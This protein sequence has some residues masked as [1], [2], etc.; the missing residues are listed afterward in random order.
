MSETPNRIEVLAGELETLRSEIAELDALDAPTDEQSERF[1]VALTE[2]DE[3]TAEHT[4]LVERA[5]KVAKVRDTA[6]RTPPE[7]IQAPN[8]NIQ[9]DAFE[10]AEG[11]RMQHDS[12][13]NVRF[14]SEET[15]ER[16][17]R[18]FDGA[19]VR[20]VK[21]EHLE[22]LHDRIET[23][24]GAAEYAL[25]HGSPAYRSAFTE[26]MRAKGQNVMLT[27]HE[28]EAVRASMALGV[29]TGGYALPTLLDPTLIHT[30]VATRNPIR[31][32]RAGRD[33][34]TQNVWHGVSVGN[35]TTYWGAEGSA[36]TDGTPTFAG[37]S[38]T[39]SQA[40]RLR[41][42]VLRDLRGLQPPGA[43]PRP[44]RRGVRL[45]GGH[46]VHLGFRIVGSEGHR[47]RD[48]GDRRLAR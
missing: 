12:D 19:K 7:P 46:G 20:G 11:L 40:H 26:Y 22:A 47:D 24:P 27:S 45:H 8:V 1:G 28:M 3:K 6:L 36:F 2:W 41:D 13:G 18:A 15:I 33:Q 30:G 38:V 16:A 21:E 5:E 32:D 31:Q 44:D 39:A 25:V 9:R 29:A 14:G 23:I 34:G 35:V 42:R 17:H 48:L 37:P 10:G 43:A 4:T